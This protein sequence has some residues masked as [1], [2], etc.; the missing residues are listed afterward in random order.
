MAMVSISST[1]VNVACDPFTGKP[2]VVRMGDSVLPVLALDRVR[3]ESAAYRE[4]V[5][6]RTV[7]DLQTPAVR[8]RLA[9]HHRSRRWLVE[10]IEPVPELRSAA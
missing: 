4:A 1:E 5:G 2:R 8:L 10:G 6:P 9:F 7:F 3:D